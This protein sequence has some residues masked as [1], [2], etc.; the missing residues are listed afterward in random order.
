MIVFSHF[1]F[2]KDGVPVVADL[3]MSVVSVRHRQ[4]YCRV[5]ETPQNMMVGGN[6]TFLNK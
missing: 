2:P 1:Y 5:G 6:M 4:P 3:T